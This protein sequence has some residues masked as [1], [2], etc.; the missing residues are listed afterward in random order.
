MCDIHIHTLLK[1]NMNCR[2]S[3]ML[4]C[5]IIF[6]QTIIVFAILF[7]KVTCQPE[8]I[9]Y[10]SGENFL[11]KLKESTKERKT[12]REPAV[13]QNVCKEETCTHSFIAQPRTVCKADN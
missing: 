11:V 2:I 12:E 9:M 10:Q 8:S 7:S 13:Y 4:M 5:S 1:Q 6:S 3:Y